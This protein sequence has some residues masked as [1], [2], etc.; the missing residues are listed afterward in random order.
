MLSWYSLSFSQSPLALLGQLSL[1]LA[2]LFGLGGLWQAV[3]AGR[4]GDPRPAQS[5]AHAIAAVFGFV[6]ISVG[7]LLAAMIGSDFSVRYVAEHS[8]ASSPLWIKI[9]GL[10]GA[11]EGSIMLWL[12]LL[13]LYAVILTRTACKDSLRPWVFSAML[14]NLLFFIGVC[15]TIASPFTP[16]ATIPTDG[17]GPNPA[18][19]N[20][21]MMAVHPVLL[22][23]GFVGLAVP[24]AYA[25]AALITGRL[26]DHWV[27]AVR[28]WT[29]VAWGF[30][31]LGIVSGGWWS[32]ETLGW[33]GYWAW[34]PV[35]NASFIPWLLATAF[36]HSIQIQERRGQMRGW[37]VWL[38]V[39]AYASTVLGT[40]LNRSGI[41]Q[42]VHAF[43]GGPVGG[44]FF[45]F[46]A[47]LLLGGIALAAWR[48][49][50]LRDSGEPPHALSREGAFLAGNWLFVVFA[51]MVL[52]GTLF[53]TLIEAVQGH[54]DTSVGPPFYNAFAV[55]LGLGLLLL[56]GIGPLLPWR[57][58]EGQSLW[59]ALRPLLI[60][61]GVAALIG[62][63]AGLRHPGVLATLALCAYN[64][65]GLAGLT[66]RHLQERRAAGLGGGLSTVF[67]SQPRRYGAYL[68]HIGLVMLALG[69]VF[70]TVYRQD[71][72]ATLNLNQQA[73]L[74]HE[75][76]E[77][78][79]TR[80]VNRSDGHSLIADI[81]IDGQPYEARMNFYQQAGSMAFPAPAVRYGLW[82]DTYLVV[83]AFDEGGQWVSVRLVESP[84]IA[85][86][87]LGT[88]VMM[89][90]TGLSL[91]S[92][93]RPRLQEA[94]SSLPHAAA[95]TD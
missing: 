44:V 89:L 42:S 2:L 51:F 13:S 32:Y 24:F 21:W 37:N 68:A 86:I 71:Q 64:L 50:R 79:G 70:S 52:L 65:A 46:L 25:V 92:P 61:G 91:V 30:L 14:F 94:V 6:T 48:A 95:A 31:T 3:V 93:R 45:G 11:L 9:T 5:A 55:P 43:A 53:P 16:L 4:T 73:S 20:H 62:L 34:D 1:L 40:F 41:V 29:L 83:S 10:W 39:L 49:P 90:G 78:T 17:A 18:L 82:G 12:W 72:Q 23:L 87:W 75:Q 33:G 76:L 59:R 47:V 74:L 56:M 81:R 35:E 63:A 15:A 22:Y 26:S 57:R 84:L 38:I 27:S 88:A 54:R 66:W 7:A 77:L 60:A 36:L 85:W 69:V 19:Q 8:M 67:A 28:R 80:S 58:A